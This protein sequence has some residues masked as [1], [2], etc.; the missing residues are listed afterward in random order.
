MMFNFSEREVESPTIY[1]RESAPAK[2]NISTSAD[3]CEIRKLSYVNAD[4]MYDK[5]EVILDNVVR[6]LAGMW[7]VQ[8]GIKGQVKE[9]RLNPR[10]I[11][12]SK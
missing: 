9:V 1:L 4:A 3:Y 11:I 7:T 2:F 10:I 6:S 8:T 12:A 5:C